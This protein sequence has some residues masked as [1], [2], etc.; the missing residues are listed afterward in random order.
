MRPAGGLGDVGD[1]VGDGDPRQ[2]LPLLR[3]AERRGAGRAGRRRGVVRGGAGALDPRVHVRLVVV[4]DED[5]LMAALE[6]ARERLEADVV[7]AAV[8]AEDD[9]GDVVG[10]GQPPAPRE[11]AVG[12]LDAAP[13]CGGVLERDV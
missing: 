12:A 1:V 8:A 13:D 11:H 2:V 7:G 3:L 9:E 4:A 5:R 6:R 10:L